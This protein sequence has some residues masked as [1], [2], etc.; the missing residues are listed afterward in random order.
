M[1][2]AARRRRALTCSRAVCRTCKGGLVRHGQEIDP[3]P[4]DSRRPQTP[5]LQLPSRDH[6]PHTILRVLAFIPVSYSSQRVLRGTGFLN[7][8]YKKQRHYVSSIK[9]IFDNTLLGLFNPRTE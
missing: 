2:N 6:D 8:N 4:P 3:R 1:D 7:L 5:S 9:L